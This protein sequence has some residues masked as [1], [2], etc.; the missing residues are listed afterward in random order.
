MLLLPLPPPPSS[1]LVK[2]SVNKVF[3]ISYGGDPLLS[4]LVGYFW[5]WCQTLFIAQKS[6]IRSADG[7]K[8]PDDF[9]LLCIEIP[10]NSSQEAGVQFRLVYSLSIFNVVLIKHSQVTGIHS[11]SE[12]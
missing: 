10:I 9:S 4:V 6:E 8:V 1:L 3:E 12:R 5:G 2:L 11:T 7:E